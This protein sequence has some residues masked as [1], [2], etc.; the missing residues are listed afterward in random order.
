MKPYLLQIYEGRTKFWAWAPKA[1][2]KHFKGPLLSPSGDLCFG[3]VGGVSGR[4]NCN[5]KL[6]QIWSY[7][8]LDSNLNNPRS[9]FQIHLSFTFTSHSQ[10]FLEKKLR[11]SITVDHSLRRRLETHAFYASFLLFVSHGPSSKD[12]VAATV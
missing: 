9:F 10:R 12:V 5:R 3:Y 8:I 4:L 1:E 6:I 2:K 11:I 7:Q